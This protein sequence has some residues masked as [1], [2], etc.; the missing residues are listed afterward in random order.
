[1]KLEEFKNRFRNAIAKL[2]LHQSD[3]DSINMIL[4][5]IGGKVED[6]VN[7]KP[8]ECTQLIFWNNTETYEHEI[9]VK[10]EYLIT[11]G[12]I[13]KG[14]L[15]L[16]KNNVYYKV[17]GFERCQDIVIISSPIFETNCAIQKINE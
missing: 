5:Y 7:D 13:N 3:R 14:D 12:T 2:S 17:I 6:T 4:D 15:V 9:R 11:N 16:D 8:C 10:A 1:M